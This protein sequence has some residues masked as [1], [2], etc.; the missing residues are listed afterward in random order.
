MSSGYIYLLQPLRSIT[1]N[2][3][4]Y[5]IGKTKRENFKRFNEYPVGSIL[6]LQSSCKNCDLMEKRLLKIFDEHFIK[7]TEYGR[8]Y[9]NGDLFEMKKIINSELMN[10]ICNDN[11]RNEDI[12]SGDVRTILQPSIVF[13][14]EE[15]NMHDLT[16]DSF[17]GFNA[18]VKKVID[19]I[20]NCKN[21]DFETVRKNDYTKH[22]L[23]AKHLRAVNENICT[24]TENIA[25]ECGKQYS[26]RHNLS[27]HKAKCTQ[28]IVAN[29]NTIK[30]TLNTDMFMELIKQNKELQ[31][32]LVQQTELVNKLIER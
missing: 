19:S 21:C 24:T 18:E 13:S 27:R 25:C 28:K 1:N 31:N 29:E 2:E 7:E 26:N 11:P 3:Q 20:Y 30:N 5:K 32:M 8:E 22:L 6:L 12:N 9:F 14:S 17:A 16:N 4:I 10:E 15:A 23:T